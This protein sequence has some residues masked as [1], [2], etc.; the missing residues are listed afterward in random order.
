M[1]QVVLHIGSPKTGSTSIQETLALAT[2]EGDLPGI[3]YPLSLFRGMNVNHRFIEALYRRQGRLTR[4]FRGNYKNRTGRLR[5]DVADFRK[6]LY[7]SIAGSDRTIISAEN[8]CGFNQAEISALK[9]DMLSHGV[10]DFLVLL[11]MRKPASTYLSAMQQQIKRSWYI[12]SPVEYRNH[13]RR[14][15]EN[16]E[17][18][19]PGKLVVRPFDRALLYNNDVIDDFFQPVSEFLNYWGKPSRYIRANTS[20]SVDSMFL[21]YKYR[22]V[23]HKR[24]NNKR[25]RDAAILLKILQDLSAEPGSK[26]PEL[27]DAVSRII[28]ANHADDLHWLKDRYGIDYLPDTCMSHGALESVP[29]KQSVTLDDII[30]ECGTDAMQDLVRRVMNKLANNAPMYRIPVSSRLDR[31][32]NPSLYRR[33]ITWLMTR[34]IRFRLQS[35]SRHI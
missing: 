20:L 24:G 12:K 14:N 3:N 1:K 21:F 33:Q 34:L 31:Q 16:W 5:R 2:R 23:F 11:Y 26:L 10:D 7:E 9:E 4:V 6:N 22:K 8:L 28:D 18:V 19:F 30:K 27:K 17:A 15:I 35:L 29:Q 13:F 32:E 25:K